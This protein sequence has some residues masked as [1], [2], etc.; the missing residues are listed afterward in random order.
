MNNKRL[1][2]KENLKPL[3]VLSGICLTIAIVLGLVN[4]FAAPVIEERNAAA[5]K[6]SLSIV[7]PDGEF[8]A[9]PDELKANAPETIKNVYTE[10]SGK[11]YVVVLVT[12]KGYTGKEIG[13][14]VAI[15]TEGKIIKAV[16]TKNEESIVPSN[17]KPMGTYGDAYTDATAETVTDVDTGATVKFSESAIKGALTDAFVYLGFAEGDDGKKEELPRTDDEII[18][19]GKELIGEDVLLTDVTPE[20][21]ETVKRIYRAG[22]GKGYIAY[23]LVISAQYGTVESETLLHIGNN[24]KIVNVNKLTW[25]T[26]DAIYGYVPPTEE[27]VNEFYEKLPG[28]NSAEVG[29]MEKP[30]LVSNATNTSTNVRNSLVEALVAVDDLIRKD[31]PT[32]ESEIMALGKELIGKDVSLTDVTPDSTTYVKRAYRASGNNG[33]ILYAVVINYNYNRVETETLLHIGNDGKIQGVKKMTWKTS[34]A[35]Y[36]YVP[37]TEETVNAFYDRIIGKN[38]TSVKDVDLVANATNTSTTLVEAI[39]ES[40]ETANA[41]EAENEGE[42]SY[43]PRIVGIVVLS[44]AAVLSAV[45]IVY[46][47]R[48]KNG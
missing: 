34:D 16:I 32:A 14:T 9:K 5:V 6:E 4:F 28:K 19:L 22:G 2:T 45:A 31:L 39:V 26:S 18:S 3:I 30:D 41:L 12:T 40:I 23:T 47:K 21:M 42:P 36:G 43:A 11:G 29:A 48:R 37:P 13:L 27:T 20:G 33:Y 10:K 46:S 24:G 38:A 25:K 15:D 17:M 7:M 8:G 1:F 44:L 35:M